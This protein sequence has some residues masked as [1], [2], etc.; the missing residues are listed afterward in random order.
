[1]SRSNASTR[2]FQHLHVSIVLPAMLLIAAIPARAQQPTTIPISADRPGQATPPSIMLPGCA[3]LEAGVQL[4]SDKV[5]EGSRSVTTQTLSAPGALLRIGM[6]K[7]MEL[8]LSTEYRSVQPDQGPTIAT[9]GVVGASIGTKLGVAQ[10]EGAIPE[11]AFLLTLGL[12]KIG[13]ENFRPASVAPSFTFLM[14]NTLSNSAS[15]YYNLGAFW[16]G[17]NPSGTGFY[18]LS[19]GASLAGDLSGFAEVYGTMAT[20]VRPAH[21]VDAGLSYIVV[22]NLQLDAFGGVGISPNAADYFV[23]AGLSV[24]LPR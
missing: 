6:L 20:G 3:Q 5:G 13:S 16:D 17:T 18:A 11:T 2:L 10:E 21:A 4:A 7:S 14:R 23:N 1:M 24:R 9:S 22:P 8:R 15:L 12:P 19:L